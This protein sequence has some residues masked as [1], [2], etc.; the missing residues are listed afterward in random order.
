MT[1]PT[2]TPTPRGGGD[3]EGNSLNTRFAAQGYSS[4]G[5]WRP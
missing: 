5:R 2:D 3:V 1:S 4:L